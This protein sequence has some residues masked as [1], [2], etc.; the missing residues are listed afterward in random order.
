[1]NAIEYILPLRWHDDDGLDE[2]TGYLRHLRGWADV[3][4]VDGSDPELFDVHADRWAGL[5]RHVPVQQQFP[6][7]N[8]K[9]RGVLTGVEISRHERIVLADDDVRYDEAALLA[10][11]SDLEIASLVRPQNHFSPL[12]WHARWDT[13]RS[14]LNRAVAGD[15]PGTYGVR[16]S[17]LLR[18]GGYDADTH[19][20]N[21][22]LERTVLAAGGRV[23]HRPDIFVV[24]RPPSARHFLS[25]R[26]RQ[27]YDSFAQPR[28]L[29]VEAAVLP[30]LI[31]LRRR[32]VALL[33]LAVGVIATA[34]RGRRRASGCR[35][36]PS[37]SALW[38][39]L[40]LVE[41]AVTSWLAIGARLRGGVRYGGARL[42]VAAHSRRQ[43]ARRLADRHAHGEFPFDSHAQYTRPVPAGKRAG[44]GSSPV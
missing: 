6:G 22:E 18:T 40:W 26:V 34:E 5:V 32:P 39:P 4:V 7:R 20:E 11:A 16:R 12:P 14:L 44:V 2:L 31:A 19:F 1:M 17:A 15:F 25:Q 9:V 10:V 37:S 36:F 33:M 38:A 35:V 29:L 28:R 30:T 13:A 3:T 27:A 21:L 43:I 42:R 24:R 8:G 23:S 41:R